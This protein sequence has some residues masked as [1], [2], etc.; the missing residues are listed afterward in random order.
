MSERLIEADVFVL[1][2]GARW[3]NARRRFGLSV[4]VRP[5]RGWHLEVA[6]ELERPVMLAAA[7]IVASPVRRGVIRL[8]SG[9]RLGARLSEGELSQ[10][11]AAMHSAALKML[12]NLAGAEVIS[13]WQGARPMSPSGLPIVKAHRNVIVATGHG[14]LGMTLAPETASAVC[15]LM[16]SAS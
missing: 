10:R 1:C 3:R 5:G 16:R 14:T 12:P 8:T 7:H 6:G 11:T 13:R 15:G 9:M 2:V 4:P